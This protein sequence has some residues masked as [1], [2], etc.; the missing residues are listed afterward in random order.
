MDA[1]GPPPIHCEDPPARPPVVVSQYATA[2]GA[3]TATLQ[4]KVN[5]L[6]WS[7][8]TY[9]VE[10][11]AGRCSEGGCPH[12]S[13]VPKALLSDLVTSE[14]LKSA[15]VSL[16]GLAPASAYHYRFIA[17]SGGGGP[18]YGP[19]PQG[20]EGVGGAASYAAGREGTFRT[21]SSPAAAGPCPANEALREG[22]SAALPDCRAYELVSPL[23]KANGDA[24]LLPATKLA[25]LNQAAHS[26][27]G[28]TY[29]SLTP[30]AEPEGAPFLSQ[31]LA[32]RDPAAGWSDEDIS[33][34][35]TLTPLKELGLGAA[36]HNEFKAF[37]DDLCAAWLV[38]VSSSTLAG[39]AIPGWVNLYRRQGCGGGAEYE[40]LSTEAPRGRPAGLHSTLGVVGV[41][42]DGS[43]AAFVSD[44]AF[45]DAPP[46][47]EGI[48][49]G[50]IPARLQLYVQ[51]PGGLRFACHLP[52]GAQAGGPCGAGL[53]GPS[54]DNA[55]DAKGSAVQGALSD[56][57]ASLYW[58]AYEGRRTTAPFPARST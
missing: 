24:A 16:T 27:D 29:S 55:N 56:D 26:G 7:D 58:T 21:L 46:L 13:P 11:G 40:A 36:L 32:R 5:P 42:A 2:A 49:D 31:Y 28:F 20:E 30:Y 10:Y 18:E 52:S 8:T 38:H 41:S 48:T 6:F 23:D 12:R 54:P 53:S 9:Q 4:A 25:E 1:Y 22:L 44:G 3:D 35:H 17:S 14:V 39:G 57:G 47:N 15:E 45:A 34:P 37:S 43:E 51:G 33:P 50:G 19:R